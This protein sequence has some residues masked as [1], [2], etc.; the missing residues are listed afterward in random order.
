MKNLLGFFLLCLCVFSFSIA[1]ISA[2]KRKRVG[3]SVGTVGKYYK[4]WKCPD[5]GALNERENVFCRRCCKDRDDA[6]LLLGEGPVWICS[7]CVRRREQDMVAKRKVGRECL[8]CS[9]WDLVDA[10]LGEGLTVFWECPGCLNRNEGEICEHCGEFK[11]EVLEAACGSC[12][13]L[14]PEVL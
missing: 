9:G 1:E 14:K 6:W 12:A 5:C 4:K 11:P 7:E 8:E 10:R 2:G 13:E 3:P